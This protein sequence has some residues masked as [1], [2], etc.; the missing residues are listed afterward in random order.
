MDE[1][2]PLQVQLRI[3]TMLV[4]IE[5]KLDLILRALAPDVVGRAALL[6]P[7]PRYPDDETPA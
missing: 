6:S 7:P 5:A 1:P 4:R 2:D 3:E